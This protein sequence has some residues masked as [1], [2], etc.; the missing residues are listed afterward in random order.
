[1]HLS[2]T[3]QPYRLALVEHAHHHIQLFTPPDHPVHIH[4][5][6][7]SL[8]WLSHSRPAQ[9]DWIHKINSHL[10]NIPLADGHPLRSDT[11]ALRPYLVGAQIVGGTDLAPEGIEAV[12]DTLCT[13]PEQN[14]SAGSIDKLYSNSCWLPALKRLGMDEVL[15]ILIFCYFLE[16]GKV[17]ELRDLKLGVVVMFWMRLYRCNRNF[18]DGR[19]DPAGS[20][21]L[22]LVVLVPPIHFPLIFRSKYTFLLPIFKPVSSLMPFV[23]PPLV[24]TIDFAGLWVILLEKCRIIDRNHWGLFCSLDLLSAWGELSLQLQDVSLHVQDASLAEIEGLGHF[25][26]FLAKAFVLSRQGWQHGLV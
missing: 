7:R 24:W 10:Y 19:A 18:L 13:D 21:L 20:H 4:W 3:Y 22:I 6:Q 16:E 15:P 12:K 17:P 5:T 25:G 1:M 11:P 2:Q 8:P 23:F 9:P 26:A 14:L